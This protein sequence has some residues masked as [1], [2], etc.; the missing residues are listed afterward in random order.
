MDASEIYTKRLN[1]KEVLTTMSGKTLWRRSGSEIIHINRGPPGPRRRTRHLQRESDGSAPTSHRDS[2]WYDGDAWK[3]FWSIS[4]HFYLPSSR[5]TQSQTVR[6]ERR[7]ISSSTRRDQDFKYILAC[8]TGENFRRLLERRWR[9]R[10]IRCMDRLHK[11]YFIEWKATGW[12]Y[13]IR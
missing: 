7:I 12:I 11:D 8:N 13:I 1:A 5:G 10:I 4:G 9:M 2:S 6:T 3:D